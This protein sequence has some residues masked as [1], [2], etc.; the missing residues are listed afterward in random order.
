MKRWIFSGRNLR[1]RLI[2]CDAFRR[3]FV[4]EKIFQKKTL[5]DVFN[6]GYHCVFCLCGISHSLGRVYQFLPMERLRAK[7]ICGTAKL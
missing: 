3:L 4:Y 5:S 1:N 2:D 7:G 6:A